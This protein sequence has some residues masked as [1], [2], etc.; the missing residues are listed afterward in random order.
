MRR[1]VAV[2]PDPAVARAIAAGLA[3]VAAVESRPA[4]TPELVADLC[5]IDISGCPETGDPGPDPGLACPVIA[6]V[7]RGELAAVVAILQAWERVAGVIVAGEL[8]RL[9]PLATRILDQATGLAPLLRA[10][11]EVHTRTVADYTDKL[12]C[13]AEIAAFADAAGVTR[14][15]EAIEQCLDEML[16]N[17]LY[18]A[19]VDGRGKRVFAGVAT[20]ERIT[21]RTEQ[22]ATVQYACDG[23]Q[24]AIA[25]RDAFGALERRTVVGYLN[26]SLHEPERAVDRKVSGAG[27]GLYLMV[28]SSS[29]VHFHVVP[30]V[31][32]E[33]VCVFDL[34][35]RKLE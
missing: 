30:G 22:V 23:K 25:V 27:L 20:K 28:S 4:V 24:F 33:V 29:Q 19:P 35:A 21:W 8:D 2:S 18:D 31:A 32:T 3:S 9:A 11:T 15:R 17:A 16:M 1:I 6:I 26:K 12:A 34:E 7:P 10:N 13:M 14:N 5:V